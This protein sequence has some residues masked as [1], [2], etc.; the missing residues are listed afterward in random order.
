MPKLKPNIKVKYLKPNNIKSSMHN[1]KKVY[2]QQKVMLFIKKPSH[3]VNRINKIL[4]LSH[5][6]DGLSFNNSI[7]YYRRR[8]LMTYRHAFGD[9]G[10][11]Y[12]ELY[13]TELN[14]DFNVISKQLLLKYAEDGRL[15]VL[16]GDLHCVYSASDE[17][18][19]HIHIGHLNDKL[20]V[21]RDKHFNPIKRL[22]KNWQFFSLNGN[23]F[24][25]YDYEPFIVYRMDND[26]KIIETIERP[27]VK[28]P[29]GRIRGSTPPIMVK[30]KW[31]M[32]VHSHD[33]NAPGSPYVNG[34]LTFNQTFN[35]LSLTRLD[36]DNF[37]IVFPCG[38]TF[39]DNR[40]FVSYGVDDSYCKIRELA[41][42]HNENP[43]LSMRL[44]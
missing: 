43:T 18:R 7:L 16:N 30:D 44:R 26:F 22:E 42:L 25:V 41:I 6:D 28:W 20:E 35:V 15:C 36:I 19:I 12:S 9:H 29:F 14:S 13:I 1:R 17:R 2:L 24:C 10:S 40:G 32:L 5:G 31:L 8:M 39:Q 3:V 34:V 11:A 37:N 27:P 4:P 21:D 23:I 33:S 38:L